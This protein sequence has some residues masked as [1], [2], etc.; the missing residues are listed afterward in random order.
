MSKDRL[1]LTVNLGSSSIKFVA[2]VGKNVEYRANLVNQ[3]LPKIECSSTKTDQYECASQIL[4]YLENYSL[5]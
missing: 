4:P 1:I 5:W 2:Y 3:D